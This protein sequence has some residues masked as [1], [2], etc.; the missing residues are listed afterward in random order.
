MYGWIIFALILLG[1][2]AILFIPLSVSISAADNAPL[3]V[4]LHILFFRFSLYPKK[5]KTYRRMS[6]RAWERK[7]QA[8]RV[9]KRKKQSKKV[10]ESK[11]AKKTTKDH[12]RLF[13]LLLS[14]LS[15]TRKGLLSAFR[16]RLCRVYVAVGTEDAAKTAILYGAVSQT[17]AILLELC[18]R[19]LWCKRNKRRVNVTADF[20][21]TESSLRALVRLDSNLFRLL[22]L[23]IAAGLVFL[24]QKLQN[25]KTVQ[26]K[27]E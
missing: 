4:R 18:E 2:L 10:A 12:I 17:T 25:N 19:F 9:K 15:R 26:P 22:R 16:I 11:K 24:K 3:T 20:C 5:R 13:R 14:L 6:A 23:A 27:G 21:G 1:L 8:A 7:K